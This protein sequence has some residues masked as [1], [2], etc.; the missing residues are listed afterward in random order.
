MKKFFYTA[1]FILLIFMGQIEA[2]PVKFAVVSDSHISLP[3]TD[4][5]GKYTGTT[6]S[7]SYLQTAV[8]DI[9]NSDADFVVFSGDA[10]NST[11]KTSIVMFAKIIKNLKKPYYVLLGNHDVAQVIG[12]DKKEFYHLINMFSGNRIRKLPSIKRSSNNLVFLF[13]DGVNEFIPGTKG[14]F[15]EHELFWLDKQLKRFKNKKVVIIQHFP[16]LPPYDK[17]SE[18]TYNK[19]EYL[20]ILEEHD[21]VIS[22]ISGHYHTD[23]E[24]DKDGIKHISVPSLRKSGEYDIIEIEK[25]SSEKYIIK[26]KI[27]DIK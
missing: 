2:K 8:E 21:N 6:E 16:I 10:V 24:Q 17:P 7:I 22:L 23:F 19:D 13:M 5:N 3:K 1:I 11:D 14:Y 12:V 20:K 9:N 27:L 15:K 25:K 26:T 4:M 18:E